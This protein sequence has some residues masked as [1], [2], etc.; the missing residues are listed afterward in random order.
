[1]AIK[2]QFTLPLDELV[3]KAH[4]EF[5]VDKEAILRKLALD[6]YAEIIKRTPVDTGRARANWNLSVKA[7]NYQTSQRTTIPST[8]S[9]TAHDVKGLPVVFIANGLPYVRELEY[10]KSDQAPN[11]FIRLSLEA[12]KA[13][14]LK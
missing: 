5:N 12:I 11:G 4:K 1:M 8:V 7:P 6:L 14:G 10:G 9:I 2:A 3:E 13:K